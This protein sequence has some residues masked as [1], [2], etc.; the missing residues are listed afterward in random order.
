[1]T[2][3]TPA[4]EFERIISRSLER[5]GLQLVGF[6]GE[7]AATAL[8]GDLNVLWVIGGLQARIPLTAPFDIVIIEQVIG[9][10]TLAYYA[11]ARDRLGIFADLSGQREIDSVSLSLPVEGI[12]PRWPPASPMDRLRPLVMRC[13]VSESYLRRI[14]AGAQEKDRAAC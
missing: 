6:A 5:F 2:R 10:Q 4:H 11:M 7:R 3:G 8:A 13:R 9:G 14:L 12:A 1:M